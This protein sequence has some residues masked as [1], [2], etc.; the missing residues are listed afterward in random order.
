MNLRT[1]FDASQGIAC[2]ALP[3]A[4]LTLLAHAA[5]A[6]AEHRPLRW[7]QV[8]RDCALVGSLAGLVLVTPLALAFAGSLRVLDALLALGSGAAQGVL[9]AALAWLLTWPLR[10]R[11]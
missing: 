1:V 10:A 7:R 8:L 3:A 11:S 2:L 9:L 6:R 5:R 4:L